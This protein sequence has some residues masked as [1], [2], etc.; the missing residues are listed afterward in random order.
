MDIPKALL[1]TIEISDELSSFFI[2]LIA[3]YLISTFVAN[4]SFLAK[5]NL[6]P[7]TVSKVDEENF[8]E[9]SSMMNDEILFPV[10]EKTLSIMFQFESKKRYIFN[11]LSNYSCIY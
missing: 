3:L 2:D 10:T 8:K 4:E 1:Y 11:R 9:S 7:S 5:A 6:K